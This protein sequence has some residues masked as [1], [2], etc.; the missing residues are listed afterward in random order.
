MAQHGT[1]K[2]ALT[3]DEI[4]TL[5]AWFDKREAKTEESCD[6]KPSG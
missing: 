5:K 1:T 2:V 4:S 6:Y 3:D